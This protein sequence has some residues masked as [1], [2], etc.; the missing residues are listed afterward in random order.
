MADKVAAVEA[1]ILR[2]FGGNQE[3]GGRIVPVP[4]EKIKISANDFQPDCP[5]ENA[6]DGKTN[7]LWHTSWSP[8]DTPFPHIL[9][10][11][12]SKKML[13]NDITILPR[14]DANAGKNTSGQIY[15][16]D[17]LDEMRLVT[18]FTGDTTQN[19]SIIDLAYTRA[20]YIQIYSLATSGTNSTISEVDIT[21]FDRSMV[22]AFSSYDYASDLIRKAVVGTEIGSFSAETVAAFT[23]EVEQ[24]YTKLGRDNMLPEDYSNI[25]NE[26]DAA[27]TAFLSKA[28]A[29]SKEDL[30][31]FIQSLTDAA[32]KLDIAADKASA[33]ALLEEANRVY[34]DAAA[35]KSEIHKTCI[36]I[37]DFI[38]AIGA[39]ESGSCDLS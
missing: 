1:Q 33:S 38:K 39:A 11:E 18:D 23:A 28:K 10:I 36:R 27:S 24:F 37:A 26:I 4:K 31:A 25:K 7:S 2:L 9:T 34:A 19:A 6:I 21:T 8:E 20:K 22:D 29:Y 35:S 14:Q 5:P 13:L 12:L 32:N 17:T 3:E 15:A 30:A 16:G